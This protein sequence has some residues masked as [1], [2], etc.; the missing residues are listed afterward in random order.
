MTSP[1]FQVVPAAG[2]LITAVGGV[3]PTVIVTESV[4][5]RFDCQLHEAPPHR[6]H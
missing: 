6:H 1:T 4:A 2:V 5:Q 3:L